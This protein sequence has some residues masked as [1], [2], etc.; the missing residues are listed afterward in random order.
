MERFHLTEVQ[1]QAILDMPLR[2]LA[3]LERQKIDDEYEELIRRI[4]YLED[5]LASPRKILGVVRTD[6][7]ELKK[8]YGD[9]RRTHIVYGVE[10]ELEEE[11][12]V[13]D[14]T[15]L[16]LI[17]QRGYIKRVPERVFRAQARGGR[18]VIGMRRKTPSSIC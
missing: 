18:G 17:T 12:L 9:P 5:L 15:V 16:I 4:A 11:E 1:A 2:R 13:A 3:A 8:A 7:E 6:L 10:A 14:E